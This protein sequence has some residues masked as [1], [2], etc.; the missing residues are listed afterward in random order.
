V[1]TAAGAA[2]TTTQGVADGVLGDAADGWANAA[3]THTAG[4][5]PA[6]VDPVDIAQL[7]DG[8]A[9][10]PVDLADFA[11]GELDSGKAGVLTDQAGDTAGGP[12]EFATLAG[13][14]FNIVD[15]HTDRQD[16]Q[17]HGIA[18][19]FFNVRIGAGFDNI[20]NLGGLGGE[21]ISFFTIFIGDQSD[22]D[23]AVGIVFDG[24]D[25]GL[26]AILFAA[27]G[28]RRYGGR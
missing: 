6:D 25:L 10:L 27:C 18:D 22:K 2:F 1:A 21:D 8:G 26:D 12:T 15:F 7:A 9:A 17:G 19:G 13:S 23:G 4:L 20:A 11:G 5:T 14:H 3:M 16:F 24:F 28:R